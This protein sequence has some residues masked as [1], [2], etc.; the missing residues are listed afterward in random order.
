MSQKCGKFCKRTLKRCKRILRNFGRCLKRLCTCRG[1]LPRCCRRCSKKCKKSTIWC[2]LSIRCNLC[3]TC[4]KCWR[5]VFCCCKRKVRRQ[6]I[7]HIE[8]KRRKKR[9]RLTPTSGSVDDKSRVYFCTVNS[10]ISNEKD[11][12]EKAPSKLELKVDSSEE[13]PQCSKTV[14]KDKKFKKIKKVKEKK[15]KDEPAPIE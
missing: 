13:K 11:N 15:H 3:R 10:K 4:R 8:Y 12:L 14:K 7:R 6:R 1:K 2:P 5:K 9:G